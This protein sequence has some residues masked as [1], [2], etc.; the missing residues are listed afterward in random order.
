MRKSTA[1][2]W[3]SKQDDSKRAGGLEEVLVHCKLVSRFCHFIS[4]DTKESYSHANMTNIRRFSKIIIETLKW[5]NGFIQMTVS[6]S[7]AEMIGQ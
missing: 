3:F 7:V 4:R 1:N 6:Q 5:Q 2:W